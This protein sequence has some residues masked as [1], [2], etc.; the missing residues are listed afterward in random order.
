[1]FDHA[2]LMRERIIASP[3]INVDRILGNILLFYMCLLVLGS[4]PLGIGLASVKD[5]KRHHKSK[6]RSVLMFFYRN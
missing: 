4:L 5:E 6:I 1:M 2:H 3:E